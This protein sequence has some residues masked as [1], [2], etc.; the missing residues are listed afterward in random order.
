[1]N[2]QISNGSYVD[3]SKIHSVTERAFLNAPHTDHNEQ[4]IVDALRRAGA[5]TISQVAKAD[6]EIIGHVAISPVTFLNGATDLGLGQYL[7]FLSRSMLLLS[8]QSKGS[9]FKR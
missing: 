2:I 9:L 4:F 8:R 3:T 5:L 7:F 1:M 6:G